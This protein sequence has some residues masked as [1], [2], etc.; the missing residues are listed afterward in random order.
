MPEGVI[1]S[2]VGERTRGWVEEEPLGK[3]VKVV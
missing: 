3:L 1:V 2:L